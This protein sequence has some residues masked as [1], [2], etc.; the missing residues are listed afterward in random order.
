MPW[1]SPPFTATTAAPPSI[2]RVAADNI[3]LKPPNLSHIET[4]AMIQGAM[5][6]YCCL[7]ETGRVARG[8]KVLIHG[9]AGAVGSACV[10]L[11]HNLDARI[12]A[13]CRG[14]DRDFVRSLGADHVIAFDQA[15]FSEMRARPGRRHRPARR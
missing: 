7:V 4:A 14:V 9:A 15:D 1:C 8:E 2:V 13:T 6:A 12:A 5:A 11:A 10:E 3:A